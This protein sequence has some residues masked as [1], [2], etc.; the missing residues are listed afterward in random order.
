MASIFEVLEAIE[1]R[2]SM[3]VGASNSERGEQ[4]RNLELL[5]HGYAIAVDSHGLSEPVQ[6]FPKAFAEYLYKRFEWS[7]SAGPVAAI[8][9]AAKSDEDA[10]QM[11]WK[12]VKDFRN[13]LQGTS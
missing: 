12:L 2:P 5:L 7:A 3:Y 13:S 9:D 6:D 8:K 4:L 1:K 10:W 11:F